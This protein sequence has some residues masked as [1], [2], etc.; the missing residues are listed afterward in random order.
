MTDTKGRRERWRG[1][2]DDPGSVSCKNGI[3]SQSSAPILPDGREIP[4][5]SLH[6]ERSFG[7]LFPFTGDYCAH[8]CEGWKTGCR[9]KRAELFAAMKKTPS[10]SI[11]RRRGFLCFLTEEVFLRSRLFLHFPGAGDRFCM[12][13]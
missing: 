8:R 4:V 2:A 9:K 1:L 7:M 3:D 6:D 10:P 13:C 5:G 11:G 12:A